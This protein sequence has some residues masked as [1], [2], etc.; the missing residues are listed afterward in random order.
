M[1]LPDFP[2]LV[3]VIISAVLAAITGAWVER[4]RANDDKMPRLIDY[5]I[6]SSRIFPPGPYV[7]GKDVAITIDGKDAAGVTRLDLMVYNFSDKDFDNVRFYIDLVPDN[8][9]EMP[10]DI[11]A[12]SACGVN[13]IPDSVT[14]IKDVEPSKRPGAMRF[15]YEVRSL[16][17]SARLT[18]SFMV[19]YY[20]LTDSPHLTPEI[21]TDRAGIDL[22]PLSRDQSPLQESWHRRVI[23]FL[24][25]SCRHCPSADP[26][27]DCRC[28][29]PILREEDKRPPAELRRGTRSTFPTT[30]GGRCS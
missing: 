8:P 10:G 25:Y 17:R 4:Q 6:E 20:Y 24:P 26:S 3:L 21:N 16:N 23:R 13:G 12:T 15:G 22:R 18:P 14:R 28:L 1:K 19:S 7:P 11:Q 2:S 5:E 29:L 27:L 9:S 30:R